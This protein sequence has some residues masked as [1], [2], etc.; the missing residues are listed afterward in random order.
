MPRPLISQ[1]NVSGKQRPP[2]K[3]QSK[4]VVYSKGWV[5]A[6]VFCCEY[7]V[8][9]FGHIWTY[10]LYTLAKPAHMPC[11]FCFHRAASVQVRVEALAT[12]CHSCCGHF[13]QGW[14]SFRPQRTR[15]NPS[16]GE[17]FMDFISLHITSYHFMA[18][19]HPSLDLLG[20]TRTCNFA[21]LGQSRQNVDG[22]LQMC[23][24]AVGSDMLGAHTLAV[25]RNGRLYSKGTQPWRWWCSNPWPFE[26]FCFEI[27][28]LGLW[29]CLRSWKH[30][31]CC[32]LSELMLPGSTKQSAAEVS[33]PTLVTKFLG[34]GAGR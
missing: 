15:C 34:T 27:L 7:P 6:V 14:M 11:F 29:T 26:S 20:P 8:S 23:E 17:E 2:G 33:T 12:L 16:S 21:N 4:D 3:R 5:L 13:P 25:S 32:R 18:S 30:R 28:R 19:W 31:Q 9:E 10:T 24:V 1:C 22:S